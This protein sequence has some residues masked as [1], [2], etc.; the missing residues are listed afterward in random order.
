MEYAFLHN[1]F[2]HIH[3]QFYLRQFQQ[4]LLENNIAGPDCSL[5]FSSKIRRTYPISGYVHDDELEKILA[6]VDTETST[7][8]RD[9]AIIMLGAI[10]GIRAC[11]IIHL[12]FSDIDWQKK[13]L[14]FMQA[15]TINPIVLPLTPEVE[16]ALV[17]YIRNGRPHADHPEIFLRVAAPVGPI[18][19]AP[20]IQVMFTKYA[21]KANIDRRPYDGKNFHGLRRR[22]GRNMILNDVPLT[23]I[24]QVLGHQS[25]DATKQYLSLDSQNLRECALDFRGISVE[26]RGLNA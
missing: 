14:R 1:I 15:K 19:S 23:T 8:K 17:E 21:S 12:K 4:F 11:D 25:F 18:R 7:G 9:Y 2:L 13:E 10:L 26:R 24:A 6:A 20:A 3:K 22:L 5:L 16:S